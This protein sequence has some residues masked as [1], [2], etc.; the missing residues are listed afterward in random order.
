M[1]KMVISTETV[2]ASLLVMGFDKVD[3]LLFTLTLGKLTS[4]EKFNKEFEF[5][6]EVL[7]PIFNDF[8]INDGYAYHLKDGYTLDTDVSGL[9]G[10]KWLLKNSLRSNWRL[11][12]YLNKMDFKDIIISKILYL[13][14]VDPAILK[15]ML[16]SKEIAF[17]EGIKIKNASYLINS[18][19]TGLKYV[20]RKEND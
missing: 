13:Y 15:R 17:I 6:D 5:K 10:S 1:K 7:S 4:D 20:R 18:E 14:D 12:E 11:L 16:S 3:N 8:V 9:P 19:K 2:I